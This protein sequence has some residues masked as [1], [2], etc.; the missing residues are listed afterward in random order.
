MHHVVHG[1]S[2]RGSHAAVRE[3]RTLPS[4]EV[5]LAHRGRW[6][7][8]RWTAMRHAIGRC[9]RCCLC[10]LQQC[11]SGYHPVVK[12][13]HAEQSSM[14]LQ[15][16]AETQPRRACGAEP[17]AARAAAG[18]ARAV[19]RVPRPRQQ[20][21]GVWLLCGAAGLPQEGRGPRAHQQ[22]LQAEASWLAL[23]QSSPPCALRLQAIL[24]PTNCNPAVGR[25]V[26]SLP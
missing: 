23:A 25:L 20:C 21:A 18:E 11:L 4:R 10:I 19:R 3:Y 24:Q 16:Q 5:M 1:V 15:G 2:V 9:C 17:A 22:H 6:K 12:H 26:R 8:S 13:C 7:C 14:L